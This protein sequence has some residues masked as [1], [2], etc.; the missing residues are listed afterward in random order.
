MATF[1]HVQD[2]IARRK[3]LGALANKSLNITCFTGKIKCCNCGK[4]F[5][6]SIRRNHARFST[7]YTDE[8]GMYR[9]WVCGSRKKKGSQCNAKEIPD[10]PAD[11]R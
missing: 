8:D 1:K 10:N 2:E 9:T 11:L 5:M 6:H 3:A 7:T 4:S